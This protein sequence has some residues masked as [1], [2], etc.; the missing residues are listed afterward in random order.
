MSP[1]PKR[2]SVSALLRGV[3]PTIERPTLT[4]YGLRPKQP[5]DRR[6]NAGLLPT[7]AGEGIV[8]RMTAEDECTH[9]R[10]SAKHSLMK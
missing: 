10:N 9:Q 5:H 2:Q 1:A 3:G 7:D 6:T 4:C 8:H